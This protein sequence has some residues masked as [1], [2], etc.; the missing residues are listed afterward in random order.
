M[1]GMVGGAITLYLPIR[2]QTGPWR[3]WGDPSTFDAWL[4]HFWADRIRRA[5]S[6]QMGHRCSVSDQFLDHMVFMQ[7][8]LAVLGLIGLLLALRALGD[9]CS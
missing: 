1:S 9:G 5:Y 4:S 8:P 6:D 7:W 3:N 2:A